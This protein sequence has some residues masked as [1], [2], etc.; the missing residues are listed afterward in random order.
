MTIT[1]MEENLKGEE[2][3]ISTESEYKNYLAQI[4]QIKEDAKQEHRELSKENNDNNNIFNPGFEIGNLNAW[5]TNGDIIKRE[6]FTAGTAPGTGSYIFLGS[7]IGQEIYNLPTGKYT[8]TAKVASTNGA[9]VTLTA[10]HGSQTWESNLQQTTGETTEIKIENIIIY[11][12]SL[13]IQV[14]G[15]KEF[16]A[17]DFTLSFKELILHESSTKM[18][19]PTE[20]EYASITMT[21][22]MKAGVW[23]TFVVPF[24]MTIPTGWE[25][26]TL[27]GS[28]LNNE[29]I[30]LTFSDASSIEAGKPYMV[31]VS[32][33]V[34][35]ITLENV[36]L[37]TTLNNTTTDHVEFTGVYTSGHVPA[38]AFFIS[39]NTFYRAADNSNTMKAF[40]AY[41]KIKD[42]VPQS[43]RSL[44][45]RTDGETTAIDNSQLA[46]D[47]EVTVVAIYNLQG[48]RLDDMQEGVNI[49]Q[50]S[51]GRVVKVII[52]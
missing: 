44:S 39:S 20:N 10:T 31:R 25:V 8:L 22:N 26:K 48:V 18:F 15:D 50:M 47:N 51:D 17:D 24:D 2:V 5:I 30:S 4:N 27:T 28:T 35:E 32:K 19:K 12:G 46:N 36:N 11:N 37:S 21:R 42:S 13:L 6:E 34:T 45:Y 3:T 23:N 29:N 1:T 41:I 16:Y 14:S 7:I 38:G 43:A 33:A 49:L 52:K 40:R 9:N